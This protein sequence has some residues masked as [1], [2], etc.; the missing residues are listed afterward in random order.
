[1][2]SRWIKHDSVASTNTFILEAIRNM[3]LEEGT[4]VS[5]DYQEGGRGLGE[6]SWQSERGENLLMSLLL[7]PAFLSA[8]WQF[9]ISRVA[10]LALCD[11]LETLG[12]DAV[13][14]W[15]NDILTRKGKIAGILIEH[16]ILGGKLSHSVI[17]IGLNLNQSVF[18]EFPVPAT[19]LRLETG[20]RVEVAGTGALVEDRLMDRYHALKEGFTAR[21]EKEYTERLF[22]AGTPSVF[23]SGEDRFE[24]II[25][26]VN[27]FG[28]L[29]VESGGKIR[30]F[31]HGAIIFELNLDRD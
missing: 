18:P 27:D 5:A 3:P 1:M 6:H 28:E 21:L 26:G 11:V 16:G 15:P 25:R 13:I 8:Q 12:V 20:K 24:G 2:K 29:M 30:T 22:L 19:S 14:K 10:S 4:I 31:G 23:R 7:F 9:H 17:G